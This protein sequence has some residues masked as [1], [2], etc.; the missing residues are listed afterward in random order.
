MKRKFFSCFMFAALI[1]TGMIS[2]SSCADY[3]EDINSLTQAVTNNTTV[4]DAL[5]TQINGM[6]NQIKA[7]Q[8]ALNAMKSCQCGDIDAKIAEEIAKAL[9][10]KNYTTPEQVAQAI[11]EAL[12]SLNTGLTAE[13][14]Q[15]L[16]NA[17]HAAHPGCQCGDIQALI[18]QYL[19]DNPG[20]T[21]A[22]VEAIVKAYHDAHP[23]S[24]LTE[25]DVKSI[26]ETYINQ[27]QHFTKE[28]IEAMINTAITQA[29]ANYVQKSDVYTKSQVEAL[30]QS[31]IS[32]VKPGLTEAEVQALI[33]AAIA[34]IT[35]PE[36]GLTETEVKALITEALKDV[37]SG[38]T[39]AEV[40]ALI[41]AA[42]CNCPA[43]TTE[44]VTTIVNTAIEQYMQDHPFTLDQT[45]IENIITN[46][47]D[48]SVII[49]N[50]QGAVTT[51][52]SSVSQVQEDLQNLKDD[53]YTKSEV[54]NLINTLIAQAIS[55]LTPST[56]LTTEQQTI[57]N[58]LINTAINN[59]NAAHP[60][61]NCQYDA[62]AFQALVDAVAA[63]T[64]DILSIKGDYVTAAQ[65]V[66][67]INEVKALIPTI[68]D[69]SAYVTVATYTADM[70]LTNQAIA[71]ADAKAQQALDKANGNAVL[72]E[73]LT[74]TVNELGNLY[75]SL[76]E[77]L[78]ETTH[79]AE[80]AYNRALSNWYE[81]QTIYNTLLNAD[82]GLKDEIDQLREDLATQRTELETAIANAETAAKNYAN[83]VAANALSDAK[84]YTDTKI[85]DLETAYKDADKA[86]QNQINT[87]N[88]TLTNLQNSITSLEEG[89]AA[90]KSRLS[91]VENALAHLITSVELQGSVNPAFGYFALPVGVTSNVLIAYYGKNDHDTYFPA[92]DDYDLVYDNSQNW[93]TAEDY[94]RIGFDPTTWY[95]GGVMTGNTQILNEEGNAGKLYLTLNPSNVDF[96]GTQLK[97]V[98]SLGEESPVTLSPLKKSYDKL[99]FGATRGS[100]TYFYEAPATVEKGHLA[101]ANY[102]VNKQL[103]EAI[104]DVANNKLKANFSDL[105]QAIYRQINGVLDAYAVQASWTDD[106]G[107]HTVT[108]NY[109]IAATAIEPL[110]FNTLYGKGVK[111]PTITP[112][113]ERNIDL[114]DY[115]KLPKFDFTFDGIDLE[116]FKKDFKVEVHFSDIWVEP[117]GSIWTN[118]H[119]KSYIKSDGDIVSAPD[120]LVKEN[121]CLVDASGNFNDGV[122]GHEGVGTLNPGEGVGLTEAQRKAINAMIALIVEDR[123]QVWSAQLQEGFSKQLT[124]KISKLVGDVNGVISDISSKLEANISGKLQDIINSANDKL[125]SVLGKTDSFVE[126]LNKLINTANSTLL[127]NPNLRLQSQVFYT[128]ASNNMHPMSTAK[129][130]PTIASGDGEGIELK[131][132]SYTGEILAPAF[133]KFV[134]VTNVYRAD[135]NA[136]NDAELMG[137]LKAANDVNGFNE[138]ISGDRY[139]VAFHPTV[140]GATYEIVYSALDFH[141]NISQRKY[142]IYVK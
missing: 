122:Y 93:I 50:I 47:I 90:V 139:A 31:A 65:L 66:Q 24:S 105:A 74:T 14:V 76:S 131:L 95:E 41:D 119:M 56:G 6:E 104:K 80:V 51:L 37:K 45:T 88:T 7:L 62:D 10:G 124:E 140:K 121:F 25:T 100:N 87:I 126:Q 20:L 40:Q 30:I 73:N 96:T 23:G 57:I 92:V 46:T 27:L 75:I 15:G 123:A 103:T 67:A 55:G 89:L 134:A 110:G 36:S 113:S 77:Q 108:S 94:A 19:K 16:I 114:N 112:L 26:V 17:Y 35:H 107:E 111:L 83:T 52:E 18:E 98:N 109:N 84:S 61:C 1:A 38:L 60:D 71:A 78:D 12:A 72:I 85:G 128:D 32:S 49:N 129:G 79:K 39:E 106:L 9:A 118:V 63:N 132:T 48:N 142:Y 120:E 11:S 115:I 81:I 69:L 34:K 54:E 28:Q 64:A 130:I 5:Q 59:Y 3:D 82:Q 42:K 4:T 135:K 138:V 136:D 13:E 43:L 133:K 101:A 44:D 58:N 53:V 141:G 97:L 2:V 99:T 33:D 127:E 22:D 91:K 86:L 125:N 117:D 70:A 21:T 116:Q 8:D 29:L 68:P 137:A 102:Y